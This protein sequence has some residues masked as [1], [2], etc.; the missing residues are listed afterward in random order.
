MVHRCRASNAGGITEIIQDGTSGVL[1]PP[2]D[3]NA[4][5]SAMCSLLN[6]AQ[7]RRKIEA[8][9]AVRARHFSIDAFVARFESHVSAVLAA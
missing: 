7:L 4:L 6:N 5:S 8:G 9:A 3:A 1:V 2:G